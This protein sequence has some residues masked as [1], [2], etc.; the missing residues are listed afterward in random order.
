M[1]RATRILLT[2]LVVAVTAG[3]ATDAPTGDPAPTTGVSEPDAPAT[4]SPSEPEPSE[5][6]ASETPA[7]TVPVDVSEDVLLGPDV[8]GAADQ[9]REI[10]DAVQAWRVPEPCGSVV[11]EAS[12]ML[13]VTQG[14]GEFEMAVGVHQVAAFDDAEAAVAAVD[15]LVTAL[16]ACVDA[17]QSAP[18]SE[19]YVLEE[20][21]VGAQGHGLAVDYYGTSYDEN[22][23]E[24]DLDDAMGNYRAVTRRGNA[25]AFTG[26]L[27][28][29]ANIGEARETVVGWA[30][31][32]WELLCVHDSEGC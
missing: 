17:A 28:G 8:L 10:D 25:V 26:T 32:A 27:G 1:R 23:A 31:A 18:G 5:A 6:A 14:D 24:D 30:Q 13:T 15:T 2:A 16:T 29:E 21:A 19:I 7:A 11:P 4:P 12:S 9:T 3:C 20:I 22:A